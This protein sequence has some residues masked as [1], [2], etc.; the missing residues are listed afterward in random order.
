MALVLSE[1]FLD[2][3]TMIVFAFIGLGIK[4]FFGGLNENNL[5]PQS[6]P[7][8]AAVW[9]YGVTGLAL[10]VMM[11]INFALTSQKDGFSK[12]NKLDSSP[13]KFVG[14]LMSQSM[15][16]VAT[17][18]IILWL[19]MVN[20]SYASRINTGRVSTD[21]YRFGNASTILLILQIY[22]LFNFMRAK[23]NDA[24]PKDGFNPA[25]HANRLGFAIYFLTLLNLIL[26]GIVNIELKF[27][28]TDG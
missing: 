6:G 25:Q 27:F 11:V 22:V 4:L 28:S 13:W 7:A 5:N 10:L 23:A 9:G 26:T 19:I 21:F 20:A 2:M 14:G 16:S 18:V 24:T 1:L 12:M 8:N 17:L 3:N 15:P